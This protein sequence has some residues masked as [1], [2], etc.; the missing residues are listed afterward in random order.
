MRIWL[1]L[2]NS[3]RYLTGYTVW[4]WGSNWVIWC[5]SQ[6]KTLHTVFASAAE[7][8]NQQYWFLCMYCKKWMSYISSELR[9][10][11]LTLGWTWLIVFW[12]GCRGGWSSECPER[13]RMTQIGDYKAAVVSSLRS[14]FLELVA[15]FFIIKRI[16]CDLCI[17]RNKFTAQD[18]FY[19][20]PLNKCRG[21]N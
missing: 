9:A 12:S 1:H 10:A 6:L 4:I 2:H 14:H 17:T 18:V 7:Q 3:V 13:R 20:Q 15:P 5:Q 21:L 16:S 11:L 8:Q 19:N